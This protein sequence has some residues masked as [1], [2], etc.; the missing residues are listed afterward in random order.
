M[1]PRRLPPLA[2]PIE[3]E[4]LPAWLH[5]FAEPLDLPPAILMFDAADAKR[6]ANPLWWR[7]PPLAVLERL[8]AHSG[9]PL[10]TWNP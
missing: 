8:A 2:A 3:G 1:G 6:L 4:G 10:G 7:H 9:A 5:R